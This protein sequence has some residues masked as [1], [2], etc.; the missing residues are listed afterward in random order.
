MMETNNIDCCNPFSENPG[1]VW[2]RLEH[3]GRYLFAKD[4]LYSNN[5]KTVI[6]A[7]SG[8]GYGSK[9]LAEGDLKV[10]AVDKNGTYLT[11]C[12]PYAETMCINLDSPEMHKRLPVVDAVV[13][14]ETLQYLQFP[15]TFLEKIA[16]SVKP[17]G[18]II[19]S[20]PNVAFEEFSSDGTN[21]N[22]C[23]LQ[24]IDDYDVWLSLKKL[25]FT[26]VQMLG[27]SLC[28]KMYEKQRSVCNYTMFLSA[29]IDNAFK[30]DEMSIR[31][32]SRLFAYPDDTQPE[33]SRSFILLAQK[34][35]KL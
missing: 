14:F 32:L 6:D 3:V 26:N 31:S 7:A 21:A 15:Y 18:W 5:C 2:T 29:N 34:T 22:P 11:E 8:I 33:E 25:G 16:T 30:C 12:K 23:Y 27:Q 13:C 9:I 17:E 1:D 20:F 19:L 4:F 10:L 35:E 24:T 28:H